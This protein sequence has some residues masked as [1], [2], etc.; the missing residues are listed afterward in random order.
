MPRTPAGVAPRGGAELATFVVAPPAWEEARKR[1]HEEVGAC[2]VFS[3]TLYYDIRGLDAPALRHTGPVRVSFVQERATRMQPGVLM[4][5]EHAALLDL[6]VGEE[7]WLTVPLS[8]ATSQWLHAALA[9]P[10]WQVSASTAWEEARTLVLTFH[11]QALPAAFAPAPSP[12]AADHVLTLVEQA[13]ADAP[14]AALD[15]DEAAGAAM[16]YSALCDR[17][18]VVETQ[19]PAA[20]QPRALLAPLLPFQRRSLSFLLEREAPPSE[21]RALRTPCGPW[22]IQI[23][24]RELYAHI[25]TGVLCDDRARVANDDVRGAML[26]EEMGLGKTVEVLALLLEHANRQRHEEPSYWDAANE[27]HVQPVG[28]T[29]IVS[30]E[31]LRRQWLEEIQVHAPSLRVY[32]YTGHRDAS[33]HRADAGYASW[34]DWA[35][36]FDVM[37]VSFETLARDLAASH[38]APARSL[39]HPKKYERPRSPL[40]QLDFW[41]VVMDEVQLVGGNAARTMGMI[42]R[43]MSLAVSGTPVRRLADLRT[44]LWFLGVVSGNTSPAAWKRILGARL[45]PYVYR[46]LRH[47]GIRHTKVQV[48]HEMVLPPQTRY[49]VPVDFTHVETAF[50]KDV[51]HASLSA[52]E[53][54]ADGAPLTDTW[55]LDVAVLRAQ[56]QRLRQACTHPHVALRGGHTLGAG[57]GAGSAGAVN[58]RS[59][60]DVLTQMVEAAQQDLLTQKHA[61]LSRRIFRASVLLFAPRD[62]LLAQVAAQSTTSLGAEE[63]ALLHTLATRPCLEVARDELETLLPEAVDRVEALQRDITM[64][65]ERGP[66]YVFTAAELAAE[67]LWGKGVPADAPH[68]KLRLRQQYVSALKS[69]QRHW[70]QMVHRIQQFSGHC[71]FQLGEAALAQ[72][73]PIPASPSALK[74]EPSDHALAEPKAAP[75][76][77]ENEFALLEDRAYQAAEA[78]RQRL[79]LDARDMVEQCVQALRQ[80]A[81]DTHDLAPADPPAA[82]LVGRS[83]WERISERLAQLRAHAALVQDWRRQIHARLTKPVNREVD[84]ERD[85]DDIYAENLDAQIEAETLMEMY[86]PLLAQRDE[87]L[88][89]RIALGATARPQLFVELD[90]ELRSVRKRRWAGTSGE[91]ATGNDVDD[92][93]EDEEDA[94]RQAKRLQLTHFR[95][96]EQARRSVMLPPEEEPLLALMTALKDTRDTCGRAEDVRALSATYAALQGVQRRQ[97]ELLESLRRE[98]MQ[99]QALFNARA[100][101]FKQMQ[102]LSDQVQDPDLSLGIMPSLLQAVAQ[103][104]AVRQR[105]GAMEG[106]LRYLRHVED[107]QR[108][109]GSDEGELRHCFICT[110]TIERG[111]LT[112]AC[113][114]LCCETCFHAWMAHGHRTCPMCKTRIAPRDIH[115]V[116]YRAPEPMAPV[117][118]TAPSVYRVLPSETRQALHG[119]SIEGGTGSKLDG[120]VRHL[121][122]LQRTTGE[123]SLVFSS[124]ARGLDLVAESLERHGLAYARLDGTGGKRAGAQVDAFQHV[125]TVRVLLLHS[126]AQSAGLNLLAA[127]HLFLLEPLL[128]HAL[129]LQAIG[130]VHRIGQTRPTHVFGYMV[131]DTVE[132]RILGLAAT[133]GQSLFLDDSAEPDS[134]MVQ[135]AH[136]ATAQDISRE[137]QRGD[138]IG[139]TDDLL[140]CLFPQHLSAAR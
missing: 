36:N 101:Y 75:V 137:A 84:K 20:E 85:N 88:T 26:A 28:T 122:H 80:H 136:L 120:L 64:A 130:R 83:L 134:A 114:H 66:L 13:C 93:N 57:E 81:I 71:Y 21:R 125:P 54:D 50:Y 19:M 72:Q 140:A 30:P 34:G 11:V 138:L 56:L 1:M 113:G 102:E 105:I 111:I 92:E 46:V 116:V 15:T 10:T 12:R 79:L 95:T 73:A 49:L 107:M 132:E 23:G 22:W 3:D 126:E 86:R 108:A 103:E 96:L 65:H 17:E 110:N 82:G 76:K 52:L 90:R 127:T 16:V 87:L 74:D 63:Q 38:A 32:S 45:A 5:T 8:Y 31:L 106:R 94:V 24:T 70:L 35:Q 18:S 48:Q 14:R 59:I 133:R 29:L 41:R 97:A 42:R 47:L 131:N 44:S 89:G 104:R 2:T 58:L 37:V 55:E 118:S 98:Q 123:K 33:A 62:E 7:L 135:A 117:A 6:L 61:L 25:L 69:R 4:H 128:N 109:N 78:T 40:V 91:A 67:A 53:L 27:S 129:E 100:L 121:V 43:C 60:D 68:E 124:F 77:A 51:W 139:S 99:F 112:N 39:R 9:L 119:I 115:R